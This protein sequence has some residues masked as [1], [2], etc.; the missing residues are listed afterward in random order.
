[1][2]VRHTDHEPETC[3]ESLPDVIAHAATASAPGQDIEALEKIHTD[4]PAL[5]FAPTK[6]VIVNSHAPGPQPSSTRCS[7]SAA[8]SRGCAGSTTS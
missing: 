6:H 8:P 5:G 3:D 7:L 4:R 2:W 1:M